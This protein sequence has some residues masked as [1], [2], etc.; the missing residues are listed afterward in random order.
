MRRAII[1]SAVPLSDHAGVQRVRE[2]Q[3]RLDF[4]LD[5]PADRNAGP[6][7]DHRGDRLRIDGRQDQRFFAL[8]LGELRLLLLQLGQPLRALLG[9][10]RLRRGCGRGSRLCGFRRGL[11]FGGQRTASGRGPGLRRL[12]RVVDRLAARAQLASEFED[13]IDEFLFVLPA[14]LQPAPGARARRPSPCPHRR[15]ARRRQSRSSPRARGCRVRFAAPRCDAARPRPRPAW[16]AGEIATRA[17]VVSSRL[18]AL[19][20]NC[21]AGI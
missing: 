17:H 4:V 1:S 2:M 20:G 21:R 6:V 7:G 16:R 19:S 15:V 3:H 11:G 8:H 5:H 13:R 10:R 18:T 9:G 14:C 12:V